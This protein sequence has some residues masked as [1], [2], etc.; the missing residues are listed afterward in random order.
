MGRAATGGDGDVTSGGDD[1]TGGASAAA[2]R[3][4]RAAAALL[5][6]VVHTRSNHLAVGHAGA[7][8]LLTR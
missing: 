1:V 3:A 8:Y 4:E 5:E 2:D 7:K 6:D